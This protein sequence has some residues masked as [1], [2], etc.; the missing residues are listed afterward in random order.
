[1]LSANFLLAGKFAVCKIQC[2]SNLRNILREIGMT[3]ASLAEKVGVSRGYMSEL[4]SK[5]KVPSLPLAFEIERETGGAI[6]PSSW[7]REDAA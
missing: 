7:D 5:T 2:M 6:K 4:L 1:L 3:Q